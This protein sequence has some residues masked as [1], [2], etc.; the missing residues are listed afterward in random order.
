MKYLKLFESQ[1]LSLQSYFH[2]IADNG[3][4]FTEHLESIRVYYH[5]VTYSHQTTVNL[6]YES[7]YGSNSI[8]AY[9]KYSTED[10]EVALLRM[11]DD[12]YKI[13]EY[14]MPVKP[15]QWRGEPWRFSIAFGTSPTS[16]SSKWHFMQIP[17]K[18]KIKNVF[19]QNKRNMNGEITT[20]SISFSVLCV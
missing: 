17:G 4:Y 14:E 12:G 19:K 1:S 10:L 18:L 11:L 13:R 2:D 3:V 8:W 9:D 20:F 7:Q 15:R 16:L 6:I 5:G